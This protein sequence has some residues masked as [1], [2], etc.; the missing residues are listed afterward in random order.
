M[1]EEYKE[2]Y[3]AYDRGRGLSSNPYTR[4][5]VQEAEWRYGWFDAQDDESMNEE[6]LEQY[7]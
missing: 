7:S 6:M 5:T 2:G 3:G 1:T 4:G